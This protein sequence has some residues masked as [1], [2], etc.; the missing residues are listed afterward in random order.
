MAPVYKRGKGWRIAKRP[1]VNE[2]LRELSMYYEIVI[3][4]S[5]MPG[6]AEQVIT[7]LDKDQCVMWR[8]YREVCGGGSSF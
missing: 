6:I 5:S 4:T 3:F 7:S 1:G 2:F 8:L